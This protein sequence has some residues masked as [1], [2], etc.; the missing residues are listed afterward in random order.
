M[1]LLKTLIS[2]LLLLGFVSICHA[3]WLSSR[4]R[5]SGEVIRDY[6]WSRWDWVEGGD[7]GG[8]DFTITTISFACNT[9]MTAGGDAFNSAIGGTQGG[10][11]SGA[12]AATSVSNGGFFGHWSFDGG[13]RVT[14]AD[15][16][17]IDVGTDDFTETIWFTHDN[18]GEEYLFD[19]DLWNVG[20]GIFYD[21]TKY[22]FRI[23]DGSGGGDSTSWTDSTLSTWTFIAC[24]K[25]SSWVKM[26]VNGVFISSNNVDQATG[27]LDSNFRMSIGDIRQFPGYGWTGLVDEPRLIKGKALSEE[28]I[29]KMYNDGH[30]E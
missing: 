12:E 27:S 6:W 10:N 22:T 28:E 17:G 1:R 20:Y 18:T 21:G 2:S 8:G 7:G 5:I 11:G 25:D 3:S 26:Y 23:D 13:D 15:N 24:T 14:V 9:N 19:R 29:L 30:G 16:A 4:R